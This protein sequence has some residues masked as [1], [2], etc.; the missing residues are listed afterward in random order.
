MSDEPAA[1]QIAY[2]TPGARPPRLWPAALCLLSGLG[3][4][5]L[6]GCFLIGVMVTN[7]SGGGFGSP[8]PPAPLTIS[9]IFFETV[10]YLIALSCFIGALA[11]FRLGV[12][13]LKK[14]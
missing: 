1:T 13:W 14:T 7:S 9:Q 2:A 3:L 11:M 10:L 12:A 4:I 6:G 5:A 8:I